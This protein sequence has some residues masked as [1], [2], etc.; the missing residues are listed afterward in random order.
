MRFDNDTSVTTPVDESTNLTETL[1][2]RSYVLWRTDDEEIYKCIYGVQIRR[3]TTTYADGKIDR[4][5]TGGGVFT[6]S[7][8]TDYFSSGVPLT[9]GLYHMD[10]GYIAQTKDVDGKLTVTQA[11]GT[12]IDL[13]EELSS[14]PVAEDEG[15]EHDSFAGAPSSSTADEG[16][17][18]DSSAEN[19]SSTSATTAHDDTHGGSEEVPDPA[20]KCGFDYLNAT[21]VVSDSCTFNVSIGVVGFDNDT[22]ITTPVD[23]SANLTVKSATRSYVL[24]RTGNEEVYKCINGA[25]IRKNK[26][27]YADGTHD[28]VESGS[29]IVWF[30]EG[31]DYI[32]SAVS[33]TYGMYFIEDGY[34]TWTVDVDGKWN[35]TQANGTF[36]DLCEELSFAPAPAAPADEGVAQDSSAEAPSSALKNTSWQIAMVLQALSF[37]LSMFS[38]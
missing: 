25:Q 11:N 12:F 28:A 14:T 37:F 3:N 5:Q 7:E 2:T 35:I 31:T 19:P 24:W 29:D 32:S 30:S 21:A 20:A 6:F 36:I 26:T 27:T 18:Q 16:T 15:D 10:G 4:V 13:C 34:M 38:E 23:D 17:A 8:G 22:I 33:L 9:Y 1:Q